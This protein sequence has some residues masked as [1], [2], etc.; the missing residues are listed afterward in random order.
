MD[1]DV[2]NALNKAKIKANLNEDFEDFEKNYGESPFLNIGFNEFI[3]T[4]ISSQKECQIMF[5]KVRLYIR[6]Y[7]YEYGDD[8]KTFKYC[9]QFYDSIEGSYNLPHFHLKY[10]NLDEKEELK[11]PY[12]MK[13]GMLMHDNMFLDALTNEILKENTDEKKR[14]K[15][16]FFLQRI[17]KE[18]S[19]FKNQYQ[20]NILELQ[21]QRMR[22]FTGYFQLKSQYAFV[23]VFLILI[24]I[25]DFML[26]FSMLN[27]FI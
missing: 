22:D 5:Q 14:E 7:Q 2:Y 10:N 13:Y 17:N 27:F 25:I 20:L 3:K 15:I 16:E 11:D 12:C 21:L 8:D 19:F 18:I 24:I 1:N 4:K 23:S 9:G 26:G 6:K